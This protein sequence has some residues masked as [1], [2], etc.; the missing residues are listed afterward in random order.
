MKKI[1]ST[2]GLF[3]LAFVASAQTSITPELLRSFENQQ[4]TPAERA[5]QNAIQNTPLRT[6]ARKNFNPN[7]QDT[8]FSLDIQNDGIS[9]QKSSGRCW[10]FTGLNVLRHH[11]GKKLDKKD[12]MFSHIY[13]FFYDQLEKSNLFLQSVIDTRRKPI[14]DPQVQWLMSNPLSDGGTFTGVADLVSKYGV[15]PQDVMPENHISNATDEF[16]SHLKRK[17]REIAINLRDMSDQGNSEK[18]LVA[19]KNQQ[20]KT[21]YRLLTIAYGTPVREFT[22]APRQNGKYMTT[23]RRY[24]PQEFYREYCSEAGDLQKDYVMLMNDPSRPYNRVYEI[25]MDRHTYDGHNWLYLNLSIQDLAKCAIAS[26]QDS[27]QMYF[28][29]DVGKFLDKET[30][31]LDLDNYD[32]QSLLG[33]TFGMD[34]RQRI[35]THD[36]GSS[37]AMTLQAVDLDQD[38]NPLKWK[39]E[40]SWG[41]SYGHHGYL[42]MTNQWFAEYM[43]RVVVN[44]KYIPQ[45]IMKLTQQK[46]ILLPA[47]DP[48]FMVE[49]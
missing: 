30:G 32:Y 12:I 27:T 18:Q 36:S 9:D 37:H 3:G 45:D 31:L 24:T 15:V 11:A 34:K 42:I 46:P 43:F 20:M 5:L 6:M 7:S 38:G 35:Q 16:N 25:D 14:D 10:M 17:L 39:V 47:W 29:C 22:W 40:N 4:F 1:F 44:R 26:L 48:M 21:V 23:P 8:Y 49:E 41:P 13:L 2:L 33:T 19:Y 28:S